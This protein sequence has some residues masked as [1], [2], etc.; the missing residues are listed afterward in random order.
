MSCDISLAETLSP[1]LCNVRLS[2]PETPYLS[3]A[4]KMMSFQTS[5]SRFGRLLDLSLLL[6][7]TFAIMYLQICICTRFLFERESSRA[8]ACARAR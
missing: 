2:L 1:S 6:A 4:C 7:L 3:H 8:H 5:T